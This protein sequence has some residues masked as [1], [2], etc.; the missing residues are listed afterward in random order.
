MITHVPCGGTETLPAGA[1]LLD[2]EHL[3]IDGVGGWF[4]YA[5][6]VYVWNDCPG[7]SLVAR[8]VFDVD[9]LALMTDTELETL[10]LH[11]M[12]H[13]IGIG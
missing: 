5:A 10:Y 4:G 1:L 6:P 9:D 7:V 2:A 12:G 13:A 11:E 3:N 8:M